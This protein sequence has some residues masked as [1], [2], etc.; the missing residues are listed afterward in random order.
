MH[1]CTQSMC[2]YMYMYLYIHACTLYMYTGS[3]YKIYIIS[4][5]IDKLYCA[6]TIAHLH[7]QTAVGME[8][9]MRYILPQVSGVW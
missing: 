2:M 7:V 3:K 8:D 4:T 5:T 6:F 1:M 9:S